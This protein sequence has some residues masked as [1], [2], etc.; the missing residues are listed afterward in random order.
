MIIEKKYTNDDVLQWLE[1]WYKWSSL[2]LDGRRVC[3]IGSMGA[4]E[5]QSLHYTTETVLSK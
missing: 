3:R 5:S 1:P 2:H 4:L